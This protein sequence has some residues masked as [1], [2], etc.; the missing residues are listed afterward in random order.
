M[1]VSETITAAQLYQN[2]I[3]KKSEGELYEAVNMLNQLIIAANKFRSNHLAMSY[4]CR[5]AIYFK[6]RQFEKCLESIRLA[7]I[8]GYPIYK[9]PK[10]E[11]REKQCHKLLKYQQQDPDGDPQNFFKLS[12]PANEKIP[13]IVNCLELRYY[14]RK[15]RGIF[16]TQD[17]KAG[18]IIV[19]EQPLF[20][21]AMNHHL[22][23]GICLKQNMLNLMHDDDGSKCV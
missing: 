20:A 18:D 8:N 23:C 16:T 14:G 15:E 13:F 9:L 1:Q 19:I 12:Y 21:D 3:T 10:L 2:A 4:E 11:K 6:I 22:Q 17:L 7:K 5:S